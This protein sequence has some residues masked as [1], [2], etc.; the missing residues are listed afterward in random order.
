MKKSIMWRHIDQEKEMLERLLDSGQVGEWASRCN[1]EKIQKVIF[2]A[3][4]SSLNIASVSGKLYQKLAKVEV[5]LK[6]PFQYLDEEDTE[7]S[8]EKTLAIVISQTGTSNGTIHAMK[9]AKMKGIPVLALTEREQT[10]IQQLGDYYMNFLCEQEDCNAKTKG[11]SNSMVLLWLIALEIGRAKG[12]VDEKTFDA[13]MNEIRACVMDIPE[14]VEQ[15]KAW[16]EKNK[17]WAIIGHFL[18]IGGGMNYGTA[19]EG[20]LKLMET[21]CIPA[22]VCE[23]GEFSHGVHRTIGSSSNV[24]TIVTKE[25]GFD[26]MMKINRYLEGKVARLL[27]IDA[28]E[29]PRAD[30][31]ICVNFRPL[32]ASA[33]NVAVVFQVLAA[34]LPEIIG[35]DPNRPS[36][37]EL[38]RLVATRN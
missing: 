14:T 22:S 31:K 9:A 26:D 25:S 38:T 10:P 8:P 7:K 28:A 18:V 17:H 20:M 23:T 3:S 1:L 36:N 6:N 33:L 13:Y 15:T 37:D 27:I 24:V 34:A 32:T 11:Y 5:V 16:I 4:G 12:Q 29:G 19:E 21:L 30:N 35:Y 2:I